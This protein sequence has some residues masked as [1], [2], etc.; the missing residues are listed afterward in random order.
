LSGFADFGLAVKHQFRIDL[1]TV[2]GIS[3]PQATIRILAE[4]YVD[5]SVFKMV[6]TRIFGYTYTSNPGKRWQEK[7][8]NIDCAGACQK[9][10]RVQIVLTVSISNKHLEPQKVSVLK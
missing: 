2:V 9:P 7:M 3:A 10:L 4:I 6:N 8:T 5:T 1:L